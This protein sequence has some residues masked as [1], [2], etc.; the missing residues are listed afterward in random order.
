MGSWRVRARRAV[1]FGLVAVGTMVTVTTPAEAD[2]LEFPTTG[3][4]FREWTAAWMGPKE[5]VTAAEA[6][7]AA[8]KF[9]VIASHPA[10]LRAHVGAMRAANPKLRLLAYVNATWSDPGTYPDAWY[11]RDRAGAKVLWLPYGTHLMDISRAEW[12]AEVLRLCHD[13]SATAAFD[14]CLLDNLGVS[15]VAYAA[16]KS[17]LAVDP[18]TGVE[19]TAADWLN[20]TAAIATTTA[21]GAVGML[22]TGNGLGNAK[23]YWDPLAPTSILADRLDGSM[24]EQFVRAPTQEATAFKTETEW[25]QEVDMVVDAQRRGTAV[26]AMTKVW[27]DATNAQRNALHRFALSS[28]LLASNGKS[29]FSFLRDESPNAPFDSHPYHDIKIGWPL[30]KYAKIGG[31]YR[32]DFQR[33]IVLANPTDA[34]VT[35]VLGGS[36]RD[37]SG[38]VR[39]KA[40][41]APNQGNVYTAT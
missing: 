2:A 14:G 1:A 32:R 17:G 6:V 16:D 29:Y 24:P 7:A 22:V 19:W 21:T 41:L 26:M 28:F 36:Y 18:R 37:L 11:A 25:R 34:T 9:D 23:R 35:V 33:G 20:R 31:V 38:V 13:A 8:K 3:R 12:R 27:V 40:T 5:A 4:V 10:M 39:T 15:P 30:A